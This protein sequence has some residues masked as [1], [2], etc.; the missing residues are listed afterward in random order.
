MCQNLDD[1][2]IIIM[3]RVTIQTTKLQFYYLRKSKK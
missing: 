2:Q 3:L 1:N